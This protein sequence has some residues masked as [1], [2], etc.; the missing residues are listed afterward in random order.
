MYFDGKKVVKKLLIVS[1]VVKIFDEVKVGGCKKLWNWVVFSF[2]GLSERN[3]L[4]VI[5]NE[6]KYCIYNVKF[7]NKV[8]L[9]LVIVRII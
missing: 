5:N 2:V 1:F 3:I 8:I 4:W 7:I 6:V 9:R